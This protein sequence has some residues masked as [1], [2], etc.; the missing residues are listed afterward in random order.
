MWLL[1]LAVAWARPPAPPEE[2]PV[3][4]AGVLVRDGDWDRAGTLLR[5]VT[6]DAEGTDLRR[7]WTLYGLWQLHENLPAEAAT[8]FT[9]ALAQPGEGTD[10]LTLHLARAWIAASDPQAALRALEQGPEAGT[11]LAGWWLLKAQALEQLGHNDEA[12]AT[13]G[14]GAERFPDPPDLLRQQVLLLVRLGL[15]GTARELAA[16]LLKRPDSGARDAITVAEALRRG[17]QPHEAMVVLEAARMSLGDTRDI[18]IAMARTAIDDGQPGTAGRL[19][20]RAAIDD[21]ALHLEA[22]EAYRRAHD[23]A[24]AL[25]MNGAVLDPVAKLRQRLGLLLEAESWDRAV[26]LV[27][28]LER[29]GL[30]QEDQV[31]YGIAFAAYQLDDWELCE[32]WLAAITDPDVFARATAL[33]EA[34]ASCEDCP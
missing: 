16:G 15:Y 10:L 7:Y 12:F 27:E 14:I 13:L 3:A 11:T 18:L 19:L 6:P 28:R 1:L 23:F 32:R 29:L 21:P 30:A 31:A 20:E 9:N 34:M 22:A 5:S 33:R 26:A 24:S 25:R 2:D 4:L 17:G 8:S